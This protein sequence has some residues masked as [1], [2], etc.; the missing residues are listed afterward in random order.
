MTDNKL[1]TRRLSL[2][3]RLKKTSSKMSEDDRVL[4]ATKVEFAREMVSHGVA[5][6]DNMDYLLTV[7]KPETIAEAIGDVYSMTADRLRERRMEYDLTAKWL[8][9]IGS[10]I[11]ANLAKL[12]DMTNIYLT[13]IALQVRMQG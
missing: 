4:A 2:E 13:A 9:S 5:S 12:Y 11:D 10:G 1:G 7:L 3:E 6:G 8:M